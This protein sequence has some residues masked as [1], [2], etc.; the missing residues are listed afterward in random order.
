MSIHVTCKCCKLCLFYTILL[1]LCTGI[2]ILSI[3]LIP[4]VF[5]IKIKSQWVTKYIILN[6]YG[7]ATISRSWTK[8][9]W[10]LPLIFPGNAIASV[11]YTSEI[12]LEDINAKI[13]RAYIWIIVTSVETL[14]VCAKKTKLL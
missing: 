2:G 8:C 14:V 11:P 13:M 6:S 9:I 4:I 10:C 3:R 5:I 1:L 7:N 12:D